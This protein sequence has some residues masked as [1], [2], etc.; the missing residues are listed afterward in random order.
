[1]VDVDAVILDELGRLSPLGGFEDADWADALRRAQLA[2]GSVRPRR[3]RRRYVLVAALILLVAVAAPALAFRAQ[4]IDFFTAAPA[5]RSAVVE[6]GRL[7]VTSLPDAGAN[8][9][10]GR[11]RRVTSVRV[12]GRE[13][14]LYVAPVAGGGFCAFWTDGGPWCVTPQARRSAGI[15][16]NLGWASIYPQ[17]GID[18]IEGG[19][20]RRDVTV[21]LLDADG[22][23][24][25]IP[26]VWVTA[27]INTGFFLYEL[28]AGRRLGKTRPIALVVVRNGVTVARRQIED[29]SKTLRVVDHRD[30]WGRSIQTTPEAV[31]S[32]RRLLFSFNLPDGT[33]NTLWVM[34][35]RTGPGRRCYAS[36]FAEG[37]EP[38]LLPGP[39][40]QLQLNY[41]GPVSGI[42]HSGSTVLS[43]QVAERVRRVELRFQDGTSQ[44]ITPRE[45]F[46]LAR[47][48][49]GH[50]RLGH[51]LVR[52]IGLDATDKAVGSERYSP[53]EPDRYPCRK[54]K[55]YGYGVVRCP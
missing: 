18:S 20:L 46:V 2:V 41:V 36:N 45:G 47:I 8:V 11:A 54:P 25:V 16:A 7:K 23:S 19:L 21:K 17:L 32:K 31:W 28:P 27:P 9:L 33:L 4:I 35:S 5:P 53:N 48:A 10:P 14:I 50:Y 15:L 3:R 49:T 22:A 30:R 40:V 12:G 38:S 55:H 44:T 39:A 24:T 42:D 37:C 1:M 29:V 43:G 51:R 6:F 52:A 26:Y 34:P 13:R